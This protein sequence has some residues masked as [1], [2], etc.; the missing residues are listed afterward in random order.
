ME[1]VE[2]DGSYIMAEI[3]IPPA[4]PC[5]DVIDFKKDRRSKL[6]QMHTYWR[7]AQYNLSKNQQIITSMVNDV[8]KDN[9]L[10]DAEDDELPIYEEIKGKQR[11]VRK[12]ALFRTVTAC[13]AEIG[14]A[15]AMN[16]SKANRLV[17]G[18]WIRKHMREELHMRPANIASL[19][20]LC[21]ELFFVPTD[22]DIMVSEMAGNAVI[23]DRYEAVRQVK[24]NAGKWWNPFARQ[25]V[26]PRVANA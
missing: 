15:V 1:C 8:A 7:G 26:V 24:W 2:H 13:R 22:T 9:D 5:P 10:Y 18:H 20:A 21:V 4:P 12:N 19:E 6:K 17:V 11:V 16:P 23:I 14:G 3:A 25:S